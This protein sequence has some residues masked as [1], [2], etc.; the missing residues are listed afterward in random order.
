MT[1]EW[2]WRV[3]TLGPVRYRKSMH[4]EASSQWFCLCSFA[5]VWCAVLRTSSSI[6]L[7]TIWVALI[8]SFGPF[9]WEETKWQGKVIK[10]TTTPVTWGIS[11]KKSKMVWQLFLKQTERGEISFANLGN[12]SKAIKYSCRVRWKWNHPSPCQETKR[13][14]SFALLPSDEIGGD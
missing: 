3:G 6:M 12:H 1:Q 9:A 8:T 2:S 4:C 11:T 10:M 14:A 13:P 5:L 7:S